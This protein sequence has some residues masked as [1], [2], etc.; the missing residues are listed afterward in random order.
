MAPRARRIAARLA[1]PREAAALAGLL[2]LALILL[3][4]PGNDAAAHLYQTEVFRSHGWRFW[5]NFWYAGRYSQVNYSL[6]YYPLAA[7]LGTPVVVAGSAAA[8][9]GAFS[10]LVR[11]QWPDLATPS[12]LAFALL[13]PLGAIVGMYPFLLGLAAALWGLVALQRGRRALAL[14]GAAGAAL[15][16]PL[17]L[18]F[19]CTVVAG[20]AVTASG[21][22]RRRADRVFAGGL[23]ALLLGTVLLG[24]AF[25]APG[26]R[27]PFHVTDLL[28]ILLFCVVGAIATRGL[29]DQRV[30]QALFAA[31]ALLSLAVFAVPFTLGA[32]VGRLLLV[33]G[34]PLLLLPFAARGFRP[35]LPMMAALGLALFWQTLP[36]VASL[37]VGAV[38]RASREDF[39]FPAVG[40]L[41]R[42]HDP[43]YRVEVVATR[44]HWEALYLAERGVPLARGWYRQDDFPANAALYA[45]PLT[46]RRYRTWLRRVGVRYVLLP[47]DPLDYSAQSEAKRLR[48]GAGLPV[49]ARMGGWTIYEVPD[50]T[51][52]ATPA[53]SITV[54]SM[55][56]EALTLDVARAGVYKLRLRYTPYWRVARGKAC[57]ARSDPWATVL[58]VD[59]PGVVKLRFDVRLGT[60]VN[61]VLGREATCAA[62]RQPQVRFG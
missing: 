27:Y 58:R 3:L 46:A 35:R 24:R 6:L 30:L 51:P 48:A 44:H 2:V 52:I 49:V 19:F 60:V 53:R 5:D 34:V 42:H 47:D 40:F 18:V 20:L 41:E 16:H 21:W 55:G 15:V 50:A 25:T 7:L 38:E 13:L 33:A 36:A 32:N 37:R 14:A 45:A 1:R 62:R 23:A 54:R 43:N 29:A 11:R 31:Y 59:R 56:A 12:A 4:P 8:A 26:A 28:I 22:R 10:S 17:S 57:V 9:A 39:W 61:T